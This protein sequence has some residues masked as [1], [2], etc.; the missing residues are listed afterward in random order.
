MPTVGILAVVF[1]HAGLLELSLRASAGA[2]STVRGCGWIT[3]PT[4]A[5]RGPFWLAAGVDAG[6]DFVL[7]PTAGVGAI[8]EPVDGG[9]DQPGPAVDDLCV[10]AVS[11]AVTSRGCEG[12]VCMTGFSTTKT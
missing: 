8:D 12:A 2:I 11:L 9:R 1:L 6:V 4:G 7:V 10:S 3:L 5:G